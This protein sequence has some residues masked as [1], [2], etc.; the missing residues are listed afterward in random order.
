MDQLICPA[1]NLQTLREVERYAVEIDTCSNCFGIW[2]DTAELLQYVEG[3]SDLDLPSHVP[4]EPFAPDADAASLV[5]PRCRQQTLQSGRSGELSMSGCRHC[6][7]V[8][9]PRASHKVM[10]APP[11]GREPATSKAKGSPEPSDSSVDPAGLLG[12]YAVIAKA[13]SMY[14]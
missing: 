13:I 2:F 7:G 9:L 3:R 12:A 14:L 6:K 4:P 8:F 5:C 10:F 11:A 1:C